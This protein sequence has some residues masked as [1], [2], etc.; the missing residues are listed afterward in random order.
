M[1]YVGNELCLE[2]LALHFL[3]HGGVQAA[4]NVIE[5]FSVLSQFPGKAGRIDFVV[6]VSGGN[7]LR[8]L[9]DPAETRRPPAYCNQSHNIHAHTR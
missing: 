8:S 1:G 7:D 2:A 3:V 6:Y 4:G 5:C 9:P